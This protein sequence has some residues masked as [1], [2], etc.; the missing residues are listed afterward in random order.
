MRMIKYKAKIEKDDSGYS[1]EFPDLPGCF[2]SGP[3]L[4]QAQKKCGRG[5]R[6]VS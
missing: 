1:V 2:S 4:S 3:N 6:F 5:T